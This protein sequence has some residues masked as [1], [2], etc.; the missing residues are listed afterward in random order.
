MISAATSRRR[1]S[2]GRAVDRAP[3]EVARAL[4]L[5]RDQPPHRIGHPAGRQI[6]DRAAGGREVL[7][8]QVDAAALEVVL[9]VA[10]DVG[11]LQRDAEVQRVVARPLARGSRRS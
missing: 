3:V 8:R 6:L 10:E 9:D 1:S 5:E 11:Q 2:A 7:E 4:A